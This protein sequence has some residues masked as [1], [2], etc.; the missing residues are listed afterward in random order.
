MESRTEKLQI[1]T[2]MRQQFGVQKF[3]FRDCQC[4]RP[5]IPQN[6]QTDRSIRIDIRVINLCSEADFGRLEGIIGRED[7]VQ[8][9]DTA[10]IWR[11]SLT[12]R[13]A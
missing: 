10:S 13:N 3:T 12:N 2:Y 4:R 7:D 9:K 1:V 11:V 5:L 8:E 6:V